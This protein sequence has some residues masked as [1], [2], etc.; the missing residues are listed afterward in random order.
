MTQAQKG[1][2]IASLA[3]DSAPVTFDVPVIVDADGNP[4]SGFKIV[5][6]NSQEYRAAD[7]A[8]RIVNQKAAANR[9][10]AIDMKTDA[11]AEKIV[12]IVD[13]QNMARAEAVVVGWF[14]FENGGEPVPFDAQIAHNALVKYP[15]WVEKIL[16]ALAE[17]NNFLAV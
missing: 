10:K 7:R 2:D 12:E 3:V 9:T 4:V 6:R 5:G 8:V 1:F 16:I 15:T 11:G 13:G 17:D 14:G